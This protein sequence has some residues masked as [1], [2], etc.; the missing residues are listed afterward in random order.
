MKKANARIGK[1]CDSSQLSSKPL[2][3]IQ[4]KVALGMVLR[5]LHHNE[6]GIGG[7]VGAC[8]DMGKGLGRLKR[9]VA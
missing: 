4:H 7:L 5:V 8:K 6:Q 9:P 1:G 3:F 2:V